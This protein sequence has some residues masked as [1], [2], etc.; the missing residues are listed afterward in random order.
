MSIST[1]ILSSPFSDSWGY[2]F[3]KCR[4]GFL[5]PF[6]HLIHIVKRAALPSR[7][8]LPVEVSEAVLQPRRLLNVGRAL[9]VSPC[10]YLCTPGFR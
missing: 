5:L 4:G 2:G 10:L 1:Q 7:L 6:A 3:G 8:S 9:P